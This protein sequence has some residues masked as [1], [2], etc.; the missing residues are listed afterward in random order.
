MMGKR[1][2]AMMCAFTV[3]VGLVS[4]AAHAK[5]Y[6][7]QDDSGKWHFSDKPPA[8]LRP[9]RGAG[10][11]TESQAAEPVAG[12]TETLR[13]SL[14]ASVSSDSPVETASIA[15]VAIKTAMG[16]G[17]GF[18]VDGSGHIITNRHVVRPNELPGQEEQKA[19]FQAD[20]QKLQQWR[21]ALTDERRKID[22]LQQALADYRKDY[23]RKAANPA[24]VLQ[25]ATYRAYKDDYDDRLR[26]YKAELD[27]YNQAQRTYKKAER[28][29][30]MRSSRAALARSFVVVLK[31]GSERRAEMVALSEDHDLALLRLNEQATVPRLTPSGNGRPTQG[32]RVFAIGNP[33]G[34]RDSVT[35]GIVTR[36]EEDFI[37]TDAQILPGNSGGPLIDDS[38]EVL[39]INTMK[40]SDRATAQGFGYAIPIGVAFEAFA[41]YLNQP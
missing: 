35:S 36:V 16:E 13:A 30:F 12:S 23:E 11:A 18:F 3:A 19:A 40:F 15:V 1:F 31:D 4:L 2:R 6:R 27:R 14:Q 26:A 22:E 10:A 24:R 34:L 38:G 20:E 9:T 28:E 32:T 33:L 25:D 37:V 41:K 17:S 21:G 5:V 8:H 7:W 29:F 39:G